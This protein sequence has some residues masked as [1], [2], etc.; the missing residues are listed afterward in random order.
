[1]S[2]G[3]ARRPGQAAGIPT[4]EAKPEFLDDLR[5]KDGATRLVVYR[6]EPRVDFMVLPLSR[7]ET[8]LC[9]PPLPDAYNVGYQVL[10]DKDGWSGRLTPPMNT[11]FIPARPTAEEYAVVAQRRTGW[12]CSGWPASSG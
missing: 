12:P 10:V 11:G 7:I 2:L 1:M 4:T 8:D 9:A 3:R 5:T 6:D